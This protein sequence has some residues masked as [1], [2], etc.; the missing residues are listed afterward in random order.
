MRLTIRMT[1]V[2][3]ALALAGGLAWAATPDEIIA[4]RQAGYKHIGDIDDAMKQ[5]VWDGSDVRG[6]AGPA[7]EIADWGRKLVTLFPP[8]TEKG[9]DTKARPE[10][11]TDRAGFDADAAALV[12]EADKLATVAATGDKAAFAAQWKAMGGACGACHR[13][14]RYRG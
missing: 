6:F 11:W 10:I 5:A 13:G 1:A 8:G 2:A 7:K 9:H 3:T 12:T 4:T 14:Y